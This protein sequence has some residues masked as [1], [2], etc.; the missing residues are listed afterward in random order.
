MVM[1]SKHC[2]ATLALV[3]SA[4]SLLSSCGREPEVAATIEQMPPSLPPT[5]TGTASGAGKMELVIWNKDPAILAETRDVEFAPKFSYAYPAIVRGERTIWVVVSDQAPETGV[6]DNADDRS[7]ALRM[8]CGE[9]HSK[10]AALQIDS[11]SEPS[12]LHT[13]SGDGRVDSAT[14]VADMK[15][16][17]RGRIDFKVNDGKR[18]EG[19]IIT[20]AGNQIV[21]GAESF[22]ETTGDYHF[23]ADLAPV[24]L[25]D[26]VLTI[27]DEHASG[28]AGAKAAFQKY[29]KAAG[30]A[31]TAEDIDPWFTPE[32]RAH[33]AAQ[34]AGLVTVAPAAVQRVFN[35][36]TEAHTNSATITGGKAI[37][38]AASVSWEMSLGETKMTCQTLML[39][40]EGAWKVGNEICSALS[41]EK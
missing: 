3:L 22:M 28:V 41:S 20:G 10:F 26:R 38:A 12:A 15:A 17:T 24:S 1:T 6:L 11:H 7:E 39:Q 19:G 5:A 33:A 9:K 8:W 16:G 35:T 34:I 36:F 32:R 31:K 29:W 40:L 18:L 14:L 13:C 25:R 4:S 30:S 2:V 23:T 21:G 27:G 37:G